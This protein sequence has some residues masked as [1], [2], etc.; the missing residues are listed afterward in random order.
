MMVGVIIMSIFVGRQEELNS[1]RDLLQKRTA[2]L[3]VVYGRRRVGKSRLIKEFGRHLNMYSFTGLPPR[4]E[5]TL[6]EQLDEFSRQLARQLQLPYKQ[7]A[8]WGDAF[9]ELA[10]HIRRGQIILFFDEIT[11]IG[12][13]DPD[14]LGKLQAAW[15]NAFKENDELILILCGSVS[16]WISKNILSSTGFYG[17]I[18]LKINLK[19]FPMPDCNIFL[20][21]YGSALLSAYEKLKIIS[22]TG[23]IPKYLEEIKGNYTAEENIKRLCFSDAGLLFSD[24][25]YIFSALLQRKSDLYEKIVFALS[26]GDLEHG[27]LFAKLHLAPGGSISSYIDELIVAGFIDRFYTWNLKSGTFSKLSQ[28][29]LKDNYLRFYL[30]YI[31][32]NIPKILNGQFK[33]HSINALPGWASIMGL[34]IENL[35]LNN[36]KEIKRMLGIYPDE[37]IA[38][39]P[40]FQRKTARQKGCQID[41]MIQTKYGNLYVCE[42]KF[43][44]N[45]IR[46]DI[47]EEV[48]AKIKSLSIPRN[49]S[50]RPV[51]IH[52]GEVHDE[53]LDSDFF[54]KIIN[55][56]ELFFSSSA[57]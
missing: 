3:V 42:I 32:P 55:M 44:R 2:S 7:F 20:E 31:K 50:I 1:L 27:E 14:F 17:R 15:D 51:L 28:Y 43:S 41:Y 40:F 33:G 47:I 26:D 57:A 16:Y 37:V 29:R 34:Q 21:K 18:S 24:F 5:T 12:S 23:G 49:F 54:S 19:E 10:R 6:Q 13:C 11:W 52:A 53:V 9:F 48:N 45:I 8:D 38:D 4:Q 46:K 36:R 22:V 39:N 56:T 25:N 35:I 30:K